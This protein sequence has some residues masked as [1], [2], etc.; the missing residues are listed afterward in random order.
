ML[1]VPPELSF[2]KNE[3]PDCLSMKQPDELDKLT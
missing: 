1:N 2:C 3:V